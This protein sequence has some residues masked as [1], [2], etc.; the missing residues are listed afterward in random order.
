MKTR[1][2]KFHTKA[3]HHSCESLRQK[4]CVNHCKIGD[5]I[6][7]TRRTEILP[8]RGQK[9]RLS[10]TTA[11]P[12]TSVFE[13][14][15][16]MIFRGGGACSKLGAQITYKFLKSGCAKTAIYL[17]EPQKVGAQMRTLTH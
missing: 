1:G 13:T 16:S 9:L 5:D 17:I 12:S 14:N 4:R 6:S 8:T 11:I 15:L 3:N 2:E 10:K 7:D